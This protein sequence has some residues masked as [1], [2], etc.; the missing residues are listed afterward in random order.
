[1]TTVNRSLVITSTSVPLAAGK[2]PGQWYF[3]LFTAGGGSQIEAKF[4][5]VPTTTFNNLTVGATYRFY[6]GRTAAEDQ[7]FLA[8][9]VMAD[10]VISA[11]PG[12]VSVD[13]PAS[14]TLA[15]G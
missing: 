7:T 10:L 2:T 4:S 6:A 3:Q 9:P 14:I 5:D 8:A 15:L 11:L 12:E 1:M 13:V